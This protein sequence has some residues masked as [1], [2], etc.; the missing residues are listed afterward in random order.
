MSSRLRLQARAGARAGGSRGKH[1][2]ICERR[3]L[4]CAAAA[5]AARGW[6]LAPLSRRA[7]PGS[8]RRS[9]AATAVALKAAACA[10]ASSM[11]PR[12]PVFFSS[13]FAALRHAFPQRIRRG[14][15]D[16]FWPFGLVPFK[17]REAKRRASL[18]LSG[19]AVPPWQVVSRCSLCPRATKKPQRNRHGGRV[20][21]GGALSEKWAG[22]SGKPGAW[23]REP[24]QS[25]LWNGCSPRGEGREGTA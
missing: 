7:F 13:F 3:F 18:G 20:A 6:A 4:P 14:F 21:K 19:G 22:S 10:F 8:R 5:P 12:S 24:E 16:G 17:P 2:L 15:G 11:P 23:L 1:G 9:P 25:A